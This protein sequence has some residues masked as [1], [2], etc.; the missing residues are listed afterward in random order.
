ME[1]RINLEK[2]Q[3]FIFALVLLI[4]GGIYFVYAVAP[5]PGHD[6]AGVSVNTRLGEMTLQEAFDRGVI[7]AKPYVEIDFGQ[8]YK[9]NPYCSNNQNATSS[10]KC[11]AIVKNDCN[12][13]NTGADFCKNCTTL[14]SCGQDSGWDWGYFDCNNIALPTDR[15]PEGMTLVSNSSTGRYRCGFEENVLHSA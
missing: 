2:R 7:G 8:Y 6:A 4:V 13:M 1:I 9:I 12:C 15:C 3:V 10:L 14:V 11:R 5:N